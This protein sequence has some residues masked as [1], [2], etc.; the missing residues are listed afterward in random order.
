MVKRT[1]HTYT[2]F[3]H[4]KFLGKFLRNDTQDKKSKST[5]DHE[6]P[7]VLPA[8]PPPLHRSLQRTV[9]KRKLNTYMTPNPT[10]PPETNIHRPARFIRLHPSRVPR[11]TFISVNFQNNPLCAPLCRPQPKRMPGETGAFYDLFP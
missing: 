2:L 8:S 7:S 10:Q 6:T 3:R 4:G 11:S 9:Q 1:K 5:H